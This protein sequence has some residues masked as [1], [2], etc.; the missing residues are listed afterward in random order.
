[1]GVRWSWF[2]SPPRR[3]RSHRFADPLDA[4]RRHQ[5]AAASDAAH[6]SRLWKL[7]E[8]SPFV[9]PRQRSR[10]RRNPDRRLVDLAPQARTRREATGGVLEDSVTPQRACRH[11]GRRLG[12]GWPSPPA[13][14][15][16]PQHHVAPPHSPGAIEEAPAERPVSPPS[17]T[18][19][20]PAG[21]RCRPRGL[22]TFRVFASSRSPWSHSLP[23]GSKH[24]R[25]PN[26][27][28]TRV[29]DE[30]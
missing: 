8:R 24:C 25:R 11:L 12:A 14:D 9:S 10:H 3:Y 18:T 7:S 23:D 5:G 6:A 19:S 4:P 22:G 16:M 15:P 27:G 2:H 17:A 21:G 30:S 1:M 20:P 26:T 13:C 28:A 29:R